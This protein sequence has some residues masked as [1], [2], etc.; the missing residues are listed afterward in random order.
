MKRS[1]VIVLVLV[2]LILII[3]LSFVSAVSLKAS[4]E[5]PNTGIKKVYIMEGS[6]GEKI[7]NQVRLVFD[8]KTVK[9]SNVVIRS[10]DGDEI[11]SGKIFLPNN[12]PYDYELGKGYIYFLFNPD[13]S[14][15]VKITGTK[16]LTLS[17]YV[18]VLDEKGNPQPFEQTYLI[19]VISNSPPI[20]DNCIVCTEN[21]CY[22]PVEVNTQSPAPKD[23]RLTI[24][25][26]SG[27]GCPPCAAI[28]PEFLR[29]KYLYEKQYSEVKFEDV[30]NLDFAKI[31]EIFGNNIA[32]PG[33]TPT[34]VAICYGKEIGRNIGAP[35]EGLQNWV[36]RMLAA[37]PTQ[38]NQDQQNQ[39]PNQPIDP[40]VKISVA[41]NT[42]MDYGSG[43]VIGYSK[44]SNN[45]LYPVVLTVAHVFRDSQGKGAI[46]IISKDGRE[47]TGILINYNLDRD[48][49]LV[50]INKV[51]LKV[52]PIKVAPSSYIN[53]I[54]VGDAAHREG[55]PN[56]GAYSKI[57]VKITRLNSFIG[58]PNYESTVVSVNGESGGPLILDNGNYLIGVEQNADPKVN[59]AVYA[60]LKSVQ[61][62]LTEK[63]YGSFV[64]Q[65]NPSSPT[66]PTNPQDQYPGLVDLPQ[67]TSSTTVLTVPIDKGN[68]LILNNPDNKQNL[69][70]YISL[71]NKGNTI[72]VGEPRYFIIEYNRNGPL[73]LDFDIDKNR[74]DDNGNQRKNIFVLD[75]THVKGLIPG[76]DSPSDSKSIYT[77]YAVGN[78][79][80]D[81]EET[82]RI[83]YQASDFSL[84]TTGSQGLNYF[85]VKIK[86][87]N[88]KTQIN[89]VP[90]GNTDNIGCDKNSI[91]VSSSGRSAI[92]T[93]F[94]VNAATPELSAH[95]ARELEYQLCVQT[96]TWLDQNYKNNPVPI[97]GP[98]SVT[99]HASSS[100]G[101][102]GATSFVFNNGVVN[103]N[104]MNIQ[105]SIERL[106]D[107][108]IPH[109]V[110]HM[111]FAYHFRQPLPRWFDEG[112]ATNSEADSEKARH[113]QMLITFLRTGRGIAFSQMVT[114][115]QYPA[116]V[117]PLYAQGYSSTRY[118]IQL[119]GGDII[120]KRHIITFMDD[121][122]E[123]T[124]GMK[125]ASSQYLNVWSQKINYH[126]DGI[127]SPSDFQ[128]KWLSW[129]KQGSPIL[130]V[131]IFK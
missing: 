38:N 36:D 106:D 4:D 88:G 127:K 41:D 35:Q 50:A 43:A 24:V 29:L 130:N 107:S 100:L 23:N 70:S 91:S 31:K 67:P 61:D 125:V 114:M 9:I 5:I 85:D 75:P 103:W 126:Y 44:D 128:N 99:I 14:N 121:I 89:L 113:Q 28:H 27:Q 96:K 104:I 65:E 52:D 87:V 71:T 81:G 76:K 68:N 84:P 15:N 55:Y 18:Y 108:V 48:L 32:T 119:G 2:S 16:D 80:K 82:I 131:N 115:E 90:P 62:Y 66:N 47:G 25:D 78:A 118:L 39:Q 116:D 98:M 51:N 72:G 56:G 83:Y 42:G 73:K 69:L 77:Y 33:A 54:K 46:K 120:G 59:M 94:V 20:C 110:T 1:G 58:Y 17:V 6:V 112:A 10:Q 3:S 105:G 12:G 37:C 57:N 123:N 93:N 7:S 109:E 40:V 124:K 49:A 97:T 79:L 19:H 63:G 45:N 64:S 101:A 13:D 102:G 129:V 8:S 117:L 53:K 22:S 11:K 92:T 122:I 26:Y 60:G 86:V 21:T 95:F 74:K 30:D 34:F 111:V